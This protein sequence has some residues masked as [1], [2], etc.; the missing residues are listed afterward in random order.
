VPGIG[1]IFVILMGAALAVVGLWLTDDR[2]V[3]GVVRGR[4]S[5]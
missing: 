3:P 2:F 5:S 4:P 1:G